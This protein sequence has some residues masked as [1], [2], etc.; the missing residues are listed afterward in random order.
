LGGS[1]TIFGT[2]AYNA[3]DTWLAMYL[4]YP[5]NAGTGPRHILFTLPDDAYVLPSAVYLVNR[6]PPAVMAVTAN[7]D[8]MVTVGGSGMNGDSRVYFDGVQAAVRAPFAGDM[9][10]GMIVVTPPPGSN[11]Q[12]ATVTVHNGDGQKSTFTQSQPALFEYR[13]KE[14]PFATVMPNALPAGVSAMVEVLGVNTT[15]LDGQT[16]L[17]FG[18]SDV[19]VNRVWVL[20]SNRLVA[21]VT[22]S[23][24]A[25]PSAS[26]VTVMSGF[27]LFRQPF[28]F[29]VQAP[30][31]QLP[32]I[33]LPAVNTASPNQ[34]I[35]PGAAV[36][37]YGSNLVISPTGTTVTL[38]DQPAQV[39]GA[40]PGQVNFVVPAGL[41]PGPVILRLHN[42]AESAYPVVIQIEAPPAQPPMLLGVLNSSSQPFDAT[43]PAQVGDVVRLLLT[44]IDPAVAA[45]PS[46]VRANVGGVQNPAVAI[47][48]FSGAEGVLVA[49]IVLAPTPAGPAVTVTVS[50]DGGPPSNPFYIP[51]R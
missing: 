1:A 2:Q 33:A 42:G 46:R 49:Q 30:R 32:S 34:G 6:P 5:Q 35:H 25:P 45:T 50:V 16:T 8:G 10:A 38:N 51:V 44:N 18:T 27:Q 36:A 15:F 19:F 47:T 39:M 23:A 48:P 14:P 22:V 31:P 43:R 7:P 12:M 26:L 11:R 21:N 13:P 4:N 37:V 3:P 17:G 29:Q 20:D 9:Q 40:S 28:G 24:K 41:R